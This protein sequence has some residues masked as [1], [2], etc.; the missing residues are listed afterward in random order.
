MPEGASAE[1]TPVAPARPDVSSRRRAELSRWFSHRA[2]SLAIAYE[3]AV[4]VVEDAAFPGRIHFVA[5]AI[6]DILNRLL[7][8]LAAEDAPPRVQYEQAFNN[9]A[10]FWPRMDPMGGPESSPRSD[11]AVPYN[12]AVTI[13]SV[14]QQHVL[15]RSPVEQLDLLF[16]VLMRDHSA[17]ATVNR[18]IVLEF[19]AL[20][21]WFVARAHFRTTVSVPASDEELC[22]QFR[23]FEIILH[24]F[25]GNFFTG[26]AEL[27]RVLSKANG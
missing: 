18:Q 5:H 23:R 4:R 26:T 9:I 17:T 14:V 22:A 2:P 1:S 12:V 21:K 15:R 7:E 25:V 20:R 27:D 6:R 3:G 24:S 13:D 16:R 10:P 19:A 11:V 8:V